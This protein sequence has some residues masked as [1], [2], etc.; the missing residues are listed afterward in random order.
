MTYTVTMRRT[1]VVLE[2]IQVQ[3]EAENPTQ[4]I[5]DAFGTSYPDDQWAVALD[6]QVLINLA[7]HNDLKYQNFM[8]A[9]AKAVIE[10]DL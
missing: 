4:A 5:E 9:T 6:E 2:E 7:D 10:G 3:I 8:K 1:K